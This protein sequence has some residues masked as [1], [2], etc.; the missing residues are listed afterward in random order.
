M[1]FPWQ[2]Y[3]LATQS[4][5]SCI[6]GAN[7]PAPRA[8]LDLIAGDFRAT[9]SLPLLDDNEMQ[10]RARKGFCERRRTPPQ[11]LSAHAA[12]QCVGEPA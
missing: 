2:E 8:K 6:C 5:T 7:A 9:T 1:M 10:R 3:E 11:R 12:A 4:L